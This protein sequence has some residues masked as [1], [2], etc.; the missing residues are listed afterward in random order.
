MR[1][2][3]A[4]AVVASAA[5]SSAFVPLGPPLKGGARSTSMP[6]MHAVAEAAA[7]AAWLES[8]QSPFWS[9]PDTAYGVT[10]AG[11]VGAASPAAS[12]AAALAVSAAS[13][14]AAP[15]STFLHAP[16]EYFA[17]HLLEAKGSRA[18]GG[19]LVDV[20][21]PYDFSRPLV[22]GGSWNGASV[23]SWACTA[24]GWD[25][26]KLRPTTEVFLVLNGEG[27]V[28]DADG[29]PHHMGPGDVVVLPKHWHGRWDITQSIHKI[30]VVHNHDDVPGAADGIVRA[31]VQQVPGLA[32]A[33]LPMVDGPMYA[34]PANLAQPIYDLGPTSVGFLTCAP[35]AFEVAPRDS[36]EV[37]F[38][39]EGAFFMTNAD[40]S[41]QR[42]AAGDTI[43][44][45]VGWS[46]RWDIIEPTTTVWT[47]AR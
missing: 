5:P 10:S 11:V 41:A 37:L 23:G 31:V 35:G 24:G 33:V 9:P 28:T 25:S 22:K 32:A 8:N 12:A 30:W 16:A 20:G 4:L 38:V 17:E 14:A 29:V 46:G 15:T 2:T 3:A 34:A 45:P 21:D 39:T 36:A 27:C 13:A 19:S 26:P 18:A 47:E 44:L 6:A 40:G 1:T 7:R 42:C 43:V